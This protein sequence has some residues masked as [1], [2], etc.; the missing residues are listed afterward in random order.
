[1]NRQ[2]DVR[3]FVI[4]A[5]PRSRTAWLAR[6]LTYGAWEC[7]H[8]EIR[9]CRSLDDVKAWLGQ[10]CVGSVETACAPF[11]RLLPALAPDARVVVVRRPV[12]EVVDSLMQLQLGCFDL[13]LLTTA[14]WRLDRKLEQIERR[15]PGVLSVA[16]A[17]LE[18][19][20]T[21]ARVFGH[22]LALP[23]DPT[24]WS[25]WA[26]INIQI[27]MV[28]CLRYFTAHAPQLSK[29]AKTAAHRIV[30]AMRPEKGEFDGVTFQVEPFSQF[31]RDAEPLFRE[32]LVQTE[33]APDDHARKNLPL[34]QL[35]DDVGMMQCLTARA[36][37]RMFGYLMTLVAP[38]MD[39]P[40]VIQGEHHLFFASPAIRGLGMRLQRA[41]LEMLRQRG[42][43][44]VIMRA[45]HRGSGPR[46]GTFYRRLGAEPFGQMYRL[47]LEDA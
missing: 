14:M 26:P 39:S 41:A 16:Y 47:Q 18:H 30:S 40:D 31:Y 5:L 22:C 33:Q 38:S 29:L 2:S 28:H 10:P 43:H 11:W 42:V 45:G 46:L 9:H 36:N 20:A 44:E 12:H 6:F 25:G 17:D 34:L 15:V 32:H 23:H 1:M 21:C 27:N 7:G 19:E 8:D 13:A 4:F 35:L 3:P 37:G 24:W